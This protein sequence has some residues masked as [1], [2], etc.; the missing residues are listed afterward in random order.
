MANALIKPNSG[1]TVAAALKEGNVQFI[2][3]LAAALPSHI[4][5]DRMVRVLLTAFNKVPELADCSKGSVW[6]S[7]L[8]CCALGLEPDALGRAYL[9]PYKNECTL[10]IG[11]KGLI[12]LAMRSGKVK[13]I[14]ADKVADMDT[15]EYELG[16]DAKLK[17]MP[18]LKGDRGKFYCY[19][20]YVHG[21][22]GS[23]SCDIM[24][25]DEILAIK[26]RSQSG[27]YNKGPWATDFDEMAKKT[28]VK[29]L[30]KMLPLSPEFVDA[31]QHDNK[32]N[33]LKDIRDASID[34]APKFSIAETEAEIVQETNEDHDQ[35]LDDVPLGAEE[36]S[37]PE[38]AIE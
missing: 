3:Q 23:F 15:F 10:Q 29:R 13:S 32:V 25:M 2:E 5:P 24:T 1:G 38:D 17:H 18:Y 6:Q 26:S 30:S 33:A 22:D 31:I 9:I 14:H 7:I 20:A 35:E 36:Y 4:T 12:D 8:D 37:D 21:I 28:V 27:K 19:Y 16:N 34:A 11:Y